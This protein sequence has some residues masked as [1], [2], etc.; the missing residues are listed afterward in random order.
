MNTKTLLAALALSALATAC[1]GGD[2]SSGG[3]TPYVP[4]YI[5]PT[6][7]PAY[8]D[9]F[10]P[11]TAGLIDLKPLLAGF[12]AYADEGMI[13]AAPTSAISPDSVFL[14][15]GAQAGPPSGIPAAEPVTLFYVTVY[16][17]TSVS[18]ASFPGFAVATASAG[19]GGTLWRY[20]LPGLGWVTLSTGSTESISGGTQTTWAASGAPIT[21]LAGQTYTFAIADPD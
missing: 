5:L 19:L 11:A 20:Y 2:G 12:G 3:S 4:P 18:Y 17:G 6:P 15:V 21:F 9:T 14:L 16:A 7:T 8:V 13:F 1:S 10:A